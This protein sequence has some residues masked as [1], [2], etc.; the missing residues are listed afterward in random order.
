[1]GVAPT[2]S[3]N[4]GS[5]SSKPKLTVIGIDAGDLATINY[6]RK[7]GRLPTFDRLM[8]T[9]SYGLLESIY[10]M[11]SPIVWTTIAT[12]KPPMEHGVRGFNLYQ[13]NSDDKIPM[14]GTV[15]QTKAIWEML[16]HHNVSSLVTAWF[17][18]WP[19]DKI[20]G[21]MIS[22][23]VFN[24]AKT[25]RTASFLQREVGTVLKQQTHPDSVRK[26]L[27]KYLIDKNKPNPRF[28]KRFGIP[29]K[30][31]PYALRHSYAKDT[32]YYKMF[33][34]M[35]KTRDFDFHTMYFQGPDLIAH[36]FMREFSALQKGR[37]KPGTEAYQKGKYTV[38]YYAYIDDILK[39]YLA[40]VRTKNETIL[41]VSDHGYE[42]RVKAILTK[43]SDVNFSKRRYWHRKY[44]IVI[45]NG[46]HVKPGEIKG[47]T[48]F[49]IAPTV[50][51]FFDLP[52]A[53]DMRGKPIEAVAKPSNNIIATYEGIKAKKPDAY[54]AKIF[55]KI[56]TLKFNQSRN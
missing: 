37:L 16:T 22:D 9:G 12:G 39:D 4:S 29:V 10:P 49:D 23:Y 26:T 36:K 24:L 40:N 14:N 32:S 19:A 31:A 13:P 54:S 41:I 1:M 28:R 45:A 6:L 53:K 18:S 20:D 51:S 56:T 46:P 38:D 42:D 2:K 44:G 34:H 47:A 11:F 17:N 21:V 15:R 50:L 52:L 3:R 35:R 55:K 27:A 5:S 30:K 33:K 43:V 25:K 7:R 8:K 48:V